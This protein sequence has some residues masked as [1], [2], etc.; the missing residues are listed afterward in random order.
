MK[1]LDKNLTLIYSDIKD[2]VENSQGNKPTITKTINGL[3]SLVFTVYPVNKTK[4]DNIKVGCV[5]EV[6]DDYFLITNIRRTRDK[7]KPK[8]VITCNHIL[9]ETKS[10]YWENDFEVIN[11]KDW[12]ANDRIVSGVFYKYNSRT[13]LCSES[14]VSSDTFDSSKFVDVTGYKSNFLPNT[15]PKSVLDTLFNNTEWDVLVGDEDEF[16]TT[17]FT[18]KRGSLWDNIQSILKTWGGEIEIKKRTIKYK[19][20][21]GTDKTTIFGYFRNNIK[22]EIEEDIDNLCNRLYVYGSSGLTLENI[23]SEKYIEDTNSINEY[24]LKVDEINFTSIT[25]ENF[26]LERGQSELNKRSKPTK[27]IANQVL[28]LDNATGSHFSLGDSIV[29]D[30]SDMEENSEEYRVVKISYNPLDKKI[31]DL[32]LG[33]NVINLVDIYTEIVKEAKNDNNITNDKLNNIDKNPKIIN[34]ILEVASMQTVSVETAHIT[35]AWINNLFVQ[36]LETNFWGRDVRNPALVGGVGIVER[37]YI[38]IKD[39][40]ISFITE[41]IDLSQQEPLLIPNPD[42]TKTDFV[43]VYYTA[44]GTETDAFKF[45]TLTR[46]S[47]LNPLIDSTNEEMF[48]VKVYKVVNSAIKMQIKFNVG[49]DNNPVLVVGAGSGTTE[50]S[51]KFVI[52]KDSNSV[53]L[54]YFNE[55]DGANGLTISENKVSVRNTNIGTGG[56]VANIFHGVTDADAETIAQMN[57]GDIYIKI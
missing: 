36:R 39:Q 52:Y 4:F 47:V 11:P 18:I 26:L 43:N 35:N 48:K 7:V 6:D 10:I 31:F 22:L 37:N 44:I 16:T 19:K 9:I 28:D 3:Y 5:L 41:N 40:Y 33:A 45:Y 42:A 51:Q 12:K 29:L 46:P 17:D 53:K 27:M 50:K 2:I 32:N 23:Q 21:L 49:G 30:D 8:K 54:D 13:Y 34:K 14:H 1:L 56:H 57:E 38:T 55:T 20:R 15:D 25:D 24:G